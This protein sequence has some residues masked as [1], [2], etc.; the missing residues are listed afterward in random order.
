MMRVRIAFY[1]GTVDKEKA[2]TLYNNTL[3]AKE[4][5]WEEHY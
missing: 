4:G 5:G 3:R 2:Q 1:F